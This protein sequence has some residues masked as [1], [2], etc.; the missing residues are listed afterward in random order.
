MP[1]FL[2]FNGGSIAFALFRYGGGAALRLGQTSVGSAPHDPQPGQLLPCAPH[3][4]VHDGQRRVDALVGGAGFAVVVRL[5]PLIEH[6]DV[7]DAQ[8]AALP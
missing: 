5:H 1:I 7:A 2:V 8:C 6:V 4:A 3:A